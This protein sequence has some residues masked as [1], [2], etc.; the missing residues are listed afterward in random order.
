M[1]QRSSDPLTDG[2]RS[3]YGCFPTESTYTKA[4]KL[5]RQGKSATNE[6]RRKNML[7]DIEA[8]EKLSVSRKYG[9]HCL[10]R[11]ITSDLCCFITGGE[12]A[13]FSE[14]CTERC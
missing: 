3:D 13:T 14:V 2:S 7:V 1:H 10:F 4:N 12:M 6:E 9:R 5:K 11:F 8:K